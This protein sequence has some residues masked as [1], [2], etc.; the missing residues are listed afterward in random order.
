MSLKTI[1]ACLTLPESAPS[2]VASAL[3]VAERQQARLA[4]LHVIPRVPL[5]NLAGMDTPAE[6][7]EREE[8]A[9][10]ARAEEIEKIFLQAAKASSVATDW[11]CVQSPTSDPVKAILGNARWGDL[12]VMSQYLGVFD[13]IEMSSEVVLGT[14]RPVL[15]VP[16]VGD[17]QEIGSRIVIA[18]NGK[19]EAAR[20]AF[21]A[22]PFL[23]QADSVRILTINP[24]EIDDDEG[25]TS[26]ADLAVSMTYHGVKAVTV[27]SHPSDI[28]VGSDLL[29]RIADESC[30]LLVMGCYG[31]SRLREFVFGGVTREIMQHMTVPVLM[32]R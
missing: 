3:R 1:V 14:G 30:D 26:G 27:T 15:I 20:A 4:G 29:S 21:D 7:I 13:E 11:R 9:L 28:S 32:S 18:W 22:L 2:V 31:H 10:K 8:Q 5:Y 17:W 16:K 25:L 6:Y 19:R 12:V 24:D 23:A